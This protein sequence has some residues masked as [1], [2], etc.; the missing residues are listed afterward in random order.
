[1]T[2]KLAPAGA[3]VAVEVAAVVVLR[4]EY[5]E[6]VATDEIR[7]AR[8][9]LRVGAKGVRKALPYKT[10]QSHTPRLCMIIF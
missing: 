4:T 10:L 9:Q 3:I 7:D 5:A 2:V 1:M 6:V 8:H